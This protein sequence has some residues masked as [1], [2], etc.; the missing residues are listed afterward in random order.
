ML[1][2]AVVTGV[3]RVALVSGLLVLPGLLEINNL[4]GHPIQ[5]FLGVLRTIRIFDDDNGME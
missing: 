5:D 4:Y 2:M 1:L 3:S